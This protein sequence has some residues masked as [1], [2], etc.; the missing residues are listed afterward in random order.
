[1][2][3]FLTNLWPK[4]PEELAKL[5]Q[6]A[7]LK[8]A[9][10]LEQAAKLDDPACATVRP[11]AKPKIFI[12]SSTPALPLAKKLKAKLEEGG[13]KE[14]VADVVLWSDG[15]FGLG[16]VILNTLQ[17]QAAQVDFAVVLFTADD[18]G[19]APRDNCV[20][21]LGLFMG[22]LGLDSQRSLL[23]RTKDS[24]LLS[25]LGGLV[26]AEL[27]AAN[28]ARE[29][30]LIKRAV[31]QIKSSVKKMGYCFNHPPKDL[32][33]IPKE[34]LLDLEKPEKHGGKLVDSDV[35]EVLIHATQPMELD[36]DL[37]RTVCENMSADVSYS[38][39]FEAEPTSVAF[40][41]SLVSTLA[42]A[43]LDAESDLN[44]DEWKDFMG[45]EENLAHVLRAL[46]T[47]QKQ[48]R[49]YLLPKRPDLEFCVH[50]A[51]HENEAICYLRHSADIFVEWFRGQ[52]AKYMAEQL[53]AK[54]FS[55]P[56][57]MVF[58]GSQGYD[59]Y[60]QEHQD[61]REELIEMTVARFPRELRTKVKEVCF[62]N[63]QLNLGDSG[64]MGN[65]SRGV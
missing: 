40:F 32:R 48:L 12:A 16:G 13:E 8:Q 29:D 52:N 47:M 39:F 38:Y 5:E 28:D 1:M 50:N 4:K 7:R 35:T 24:S 2:R 61:F 27:P 45:K 21:E 55:R 11:S 18:A 58:Q 57:K 30:E 42:A 53:R 54:C 22:A 3:N 49:I 20:F 59:L 26:S 46:K 51:K 19:L 17:E 62:G 64:E 56:Q 43:Q 23:L 15:A 9:E 37:A 33:I 44:S 14:R 41:S 10:K 34:R 31:E 63:Y 36:H 65:L 60:S 6:E 25:D